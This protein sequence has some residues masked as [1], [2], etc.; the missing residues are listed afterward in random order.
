MVPLLL[1]LTLAF[2]APAY[3]G[4]PK[5]NRKPGA[6]A[7]RMAQ[8]PKKPQDP[9]AQ[10]KAGKL[11]GYYDKNNLAAEP[12]LSAPAIALLDAGT[13]QFLYEVGSDAKMYPAS[14][15]K[16]MTGLLLA[17]NTQPTDIIT[18]LNPKIAEVGESTL[19][20]R[21]WEKF[22]SDQ[23]LTGF[24]L[25]SGNDAGV[26]I[27]E[28]VGKTVPGFADLMNK[29]AEEIGA[30]NTHFMNPHGLHDPEHYTTAHDLAL[31][32]FTAMRN[33]RFS[34]AVKIPT[35]KIERSINK[36]DIIVQS[37]AKKGFYMRCMGAD[38]IKT[39]YTVPS[40]SCYVGSATRNGRRLIGVIMKAPKESTHDAVI[41]LNW[42]FARF[43]TK[44]A[45][46]NGDDTEPVDISGSSVPTT[47]GG[48]LSYSYD[49]LGLS[50]DKEP[51]I[52]LEAEALPNIETPVAKGDKV[53]RLTLVV[54]GR[55][56]R[57]VALY[58]ARAVEKSAIA[59]AVSSSAKS[60][61][62]AIGIGAG[63]LGVVGLGVL[64]GTS[65]KNSRRSRR[66]Q[67]PK[68]GGTHHRRTR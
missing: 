6:V 33:Q 15:T 51:T 12:V 4:K 14:T 59:S 31:I 67:S 50:Q 16:I 55:K 49:T 26:V 24:L 47:A 10:V 58:A 60:P 54:D 61:M 57:S 11:L 43:G 13:G 30:T 25:R 53:G 20:V 56:G 65:T 39:G 8:T 2:L 40:G 19:H 22:K 17:E 1:L 42:A 68:G 66:R 23:L 38:G 44:T 45:I 34:D 18:C 9:V 64:L 7:S 36:K 35:R 41:L 28:H 27:A 32:A 3:A 37:K 52:V 46:K 21:P 63:V 48:D 29:R 5:P 62:G